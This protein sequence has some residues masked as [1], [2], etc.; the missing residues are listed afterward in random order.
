MNQVVTGVAATDCVVAAADPGMFLQTGARHVQR[1]DVMRLTVPERP[2]PLPYLQWRGIRSSSTFGPHLKFVGEPAFLA[3]REN[4]PV[5]TRQI[6]A[7]DP[8]GLPAVL[9]CVRMVHTCR[10][11]SSADQC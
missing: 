10:R 4:F 6:I 3:R 11:R 5:D 2:E 1:L 7:Q 9:A 8:S